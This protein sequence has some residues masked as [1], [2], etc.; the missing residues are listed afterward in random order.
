MQSVVNAWR[1]GRRVGVEYVVSAHE[2]DRIGRLGGQMAQV[3]FN[4][5]TEDQ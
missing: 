3:T 4:I 5:L 1:N 2:E